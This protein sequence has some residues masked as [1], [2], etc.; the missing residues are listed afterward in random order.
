MGSPEAVR[1]NDALLAALELAPNVLFER[2]HQFGQV[3][4]VYGYLSR[5]ASCPSLRLLPAIPV[6]NSTDWCPGVVHGVRGNGG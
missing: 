1:R 4:T 6:L 2:Y 5:L 3:S